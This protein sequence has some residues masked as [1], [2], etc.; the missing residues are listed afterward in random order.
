MYTAPVAATRPTL[1]E[2]QSRSCLTQ[3]QVNKSCSPCTTFSTTLQENKFS[4]QVQ[5]GCVRNVVAVSKEVHK[6]HSHRF[7]HANVSVYSV[8]RRRHA[9]GALVFRHA[10]LS[11]G[12]VLAYAFRGLA[13]Q[14]FL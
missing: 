7:T 12:I 4:F 8:S 9:R 13:L 14:G 1:V 6:S 10:L 11:L 2:N 5:A 3:Q